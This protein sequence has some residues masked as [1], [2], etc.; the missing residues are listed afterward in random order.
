MDIG[1]ITRAVGVGMMFPVSTVATQNAIEPHELGTAMSLVTFARKL[2]SALGVAAFGAIVIG[3]AAARGHGAGTTS[4]LD[5]DVYHRV[6]T[7]NPVD[8]ERSETM[9][10]KR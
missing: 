1:R 6:H 9:S 8:K 4:G 2:G 7:W 10:L 3:G 5:R